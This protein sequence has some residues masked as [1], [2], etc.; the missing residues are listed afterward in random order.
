MKRTVWLFITLMS[1]FML[2]LAMP[3]TA[4]EACVSNEENMILTNFIPGTVDQLC[5]AAISFHRS[6]DLSK[7][8]FGNCD[9]LRDMNSTP[10]SALI[11]PPE[12]C[13]RV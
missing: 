6:H 11:A 3:V 12:Y 13:R 2:M 1:L 4:C 10:R 8:Y 7:L 9:T 5:P